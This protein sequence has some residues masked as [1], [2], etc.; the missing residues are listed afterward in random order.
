MAN[1]CQNCG[2]KL[3]STDKFCTKCGTPVT[4]IEQNKQT[5]ISSE[6][7]QE[8]VENLKETV[9]NVSTVVKEKAK[10]AVQQSQEYLQSE[11][12]QNTKENVIEKAKQAAQYSKDIVQNEEFRNEQADVLKEK[13][14]Q[15]QEYLKSEEFQN[16]KTETVN[17]TKG[18]IKNFFSCN[19]NSNDD[20]IKAEKQRKYCLYTIFAV[21]AITIALFPFSFHDRYWLDYTVLHVLSKLS[22]IS[23]IVII[24][25]CIIAFIKYYIIHTKVI[26]YKAT[27]SNVQKYGINVKKSLSLLLLSVVVCLVMTPIMNK[28]DDSAYDKYLSSSS[29]STESDSPQGTNSLSEVREQY[30]NAE[31]AI[32]TLY[33]IERY[34]VMFGELEPLGKYNGVEVEEEILQSQFD[35]VIYKACIKTTMSDGTEEEVEI[36]IV[37]DSSQGL[38]KWN[39]CVGNG[40]NQ[41]III[42][43][44]LNGDYMAI[45]ILDA[46]GYQID[47][48]FKQPD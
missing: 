16:V 24:P 46:R 1:F 23:K 30:Q 32:G 33:G 47:S 19:I 38:Q 4:V 25:I 3:K 37:D 43:Q 22:L 14:K 45:D 5:P 40:I 2:N 15:A 9:G 31:I 28:I 10:Q 26:A 18:V 7:I 12:F 21:I 35:N 41:N 11:E 34:A 8:T 17:K 13:A 29:S 36:P 48:K 39:N 20:Y 27:N 44:P 6:N 42:M